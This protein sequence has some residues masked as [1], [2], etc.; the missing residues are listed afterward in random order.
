MFY[1]N[2]YRLIFK[3][4]FGLAIFPLVEDTLQERLYRKTLYIQQKRVVIV[5]KLKFMITTPILWKVNN[6]KNN[7]TTQGHCIFIQEKKN[8]LD[9]NT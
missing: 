4:L 8:R 5:G 9:K 6:Q 2:M 1:N 7:E 3:P